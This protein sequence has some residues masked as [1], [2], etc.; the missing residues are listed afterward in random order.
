MHGQPL[1]I[2]KTSA[3]QTFLSLCLTILFILII[4]FTGCGSTSNTI[5]T[6]PTTETQ[7]A[8]DT[9]TTTTSSTTN[10]EST[11]STTSQTTASDNLSVHFIDVGQ[12]DSILLDLGNIEVLIDGGD[13]SANIVPYLQ[14]HVDGDLEVMVATHP[15]ADHIGGLLDVFD[16]FDID[17]I[18]YNGEES[19]SA[20][21]SNFID[22]VQAE[23]AQVHIGRR[24]DHITA[25]ALTFDVLNPFNLSGTTNNN[26]IVLSL[27]Y[28]K[29]DFLFMGDAEQEAEAAMLLASDM[30]VP[31]VEILK[32]G[33]HGSRTASSI[34]FLQVTSPEVAIYMAGVGNSYG[35]PHAETISALQ[36]IGA[37]IYGT[38]VNGTIV[39]STDGNTYSVTTEKQAT[40]T[41]TSP[42]T[43][44]LTT[45]RSTTPTTTSPTTIELSLQIVSVTSPVAAGANATLVAKTEPGAYCT[46]TVYYKSGP[47]SASGLT[48]KT[49]VGTG[50]VSWTWKVGTRTT[51]GSWEIVVTASF[52][53]QTVSK[54]IYF[55]VT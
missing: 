25:G 18:C 8:S 23:N 33:H 9:I 6:S 13:N 49:A 41:T 39:V 15:H 32:V 10:I 20:T 40:V 2:G 38:D 12:G 31:D 47:S 55:T 7:T 42:T 17:Q 5:T 16:D 4:L 35:H 28:G 36:N 54:S 3:K 34:D 50:N 45:T 48:S 27:S 51:P 29:V 26:S 19:T 24:S 30:P 52:G 43:S 14:Q 46:I 37:Q 1:Y 22:L 44:T 11:T 53:G 21:Y